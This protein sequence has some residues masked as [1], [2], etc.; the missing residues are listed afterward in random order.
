MSEPKPSRLP[1]M[2]NALAFAGMG[3]SGLVFILLLLA[4]TD[5]QFGDA[6]WVFTGS[7]LT[8]IAAYGTQ[9]AQLYLLGGN[10]RL[11]TMWNVIASSALSLLT[12]ATVLY[13]QAFHE[14]NFSG[15]AWGLIG[16]INAAVQSVGTTAIQ[17]YTQGPIAPKE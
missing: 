4:F 16:S 13:L 6:E 12:M 11:P 3:M 5:L 15:P 17:F 2:K 7:V 9:C 1:P 14:V 8:Q 10:V